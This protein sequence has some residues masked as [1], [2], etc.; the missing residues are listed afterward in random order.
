MSE[1]SVILAVVSLLASLLQALSL[2]LLSQIFRELKAIRDTFREYV[3][4]EVCDEK[5]SGQH[6]RLKNLEQG[7]GHL[8][9]LTLSAAGAALLLLCSGCGHNAVVYGDGVM[10]EIGFIPDRYSVALTF[11]YGKIFTAAVKEKTKITL[12]T[13]AGAEGFADE[14]KKGGT[15]AESRLTVETGD[16]IT[17]YTVDLEKIKARGISPAKVVKP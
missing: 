6:Y 9:A 16:Q 10:A 11:R 4:R 1:S 14:A 12:D 7:G 8:G 2:F 3:P 17:G 5:M 13:R 15:A